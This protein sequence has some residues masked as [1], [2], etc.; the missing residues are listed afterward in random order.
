MASNISDDVEYGIQIQLHVVD[1]SLN[2]LKSLFQ[3]NR[4]KLKDIISNL[5]QDNSNEALVKQLETFADDN[6]YYFDSFEILV[7]KE[8]KSNERLREKIK[9]LNKQIT[10]SLLKAESKSEPV[11]VAEQSQV[12]EPQ[13]VNSQNEQDAILFFS[14]QEHQPEISPNEPQQQQ[15]RQRQDEEAFLRNFEELF[16]SP[17]IDSVFDEFQFTDEDNN[18]DTNT[19]QDDNNLNYEIVQLNENDTNTEDSGDDVIVLDEVGPTSPS[20]LDTGEIAR[21]A[22]RFLQDTNMKYSE[23][24]EILHIESSEVKRVLRHA[25][26]WSNMPNEEM[27]EL[28]VNLNR[29]LIAKRKLRGAKNTISYLRM[30]L[31]RMNI[32]HRVLA[33]EYLKVPEKHLAILLNGGLKIWKLDQESLKSLDVIKKWLDSTKTQILNRKLRQK[34]T[35]VVKKRNSI[36]SCVSARRSLSNGTIND[37]R[38][39]LGIIRTLSDDLSRANISK[40]DFCSYVLKTSNCFFSRMMRTPKLFSEYT[41][42]DLWR[43]KAI[44]Y[45]L[46]DPNRVL[47]FI[48]AKQT[49]KKKNYSQ[50]KFTYF[51]RAMRE[52]NDEDDAERRESGIFPIEIIGSSSIQISSPTQAEA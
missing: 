49:A 1:D 41:G 37:N 48:E 30:R 23:L 9:K 50:V 7:Q 8:L 29:F 12:T 39:I 28:F 47:N 42:K 52:T 14:Q 32:S 44:R 10:K 19:N 26:T 38:N 2:N 20:F 4:S 43:L 24:A 40:A 16:Q 13:H 15:Q 11:I 5:S 6:R 3:S 35:T 25:P 36:V 46:G 31:E 22:I 27:K 18:N 34:R 33:N 17:S 51:D 21:K 45:W